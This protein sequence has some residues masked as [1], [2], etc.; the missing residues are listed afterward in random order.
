A[1]SQSSFKVGQRGRDVGMATQDRRAAVAGRLGER[2]RLMPIALEVA[3]SGQRPQRFRFESIE[4]RGLAPLLLSTAV[5]NSVLESGGVS[6]SQTVRWSL[7]LFRKGVPPLLVTDVASGD[8]PMPELSAAISAPLR[9]LLGNPYERCVLDSIRARV[10]IDPRRIQWTLRSARLLESA[11]R[12][13]GTAMARCEIESWRGERREIELKLAVPEEFP[14]GNYV[15]YLG[16]G[17]EL[18][19]YESGRLPSR[20]RPTSLD[21]AWRR[22]G[23]LR[24]SGALYGA[25]FASAPEVT[26]RGHDYPEL[27]LSALA[28]L[29]SGTSGGD[30]SRHGDGA[31]FDERRHT[32]DGPLRGEILLP[33]KVDRNAP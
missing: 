27:P 18:S 9:F 12:P 19:R 3:P 26:R 33:L 16:G 6:G 22:L 17:A 10:E 2:A 28:V 14:D 25:L 24:P 13:G 20:Y 7:E 1:S 32:L 15:L 23:D 11:A 30:A 4:D 21:D 29:A 31:R 5:L 8:A